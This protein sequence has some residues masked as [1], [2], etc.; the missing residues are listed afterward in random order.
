MSNK[1]LINKPLVEAILEVKWQLNTIAQNVSIDPHYKL[2]LGRLFDQLSDEYPYHEQLPTATL[3]DEV[4]GYAV[5]H[6]FRC[7]SNDWPLV[8]M[9]PGILTVN[10]T[11]KYTWDDFS[12]RAINAVRKLSNVY[13]KMD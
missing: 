13:P 5:Q 3:P 11:R 12:H 2:A 1:N 7:A 4:S 9:G 8:Q 10:D 6:R